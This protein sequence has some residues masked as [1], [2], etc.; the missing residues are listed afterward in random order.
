[1]LGLSGGCMFVACGKIKIAKVKV[2]AID[3][4]KSGNVEALVLQMFQ[5]LEGSEFVES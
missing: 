1:M 5:D 2:R 4:N 3:L